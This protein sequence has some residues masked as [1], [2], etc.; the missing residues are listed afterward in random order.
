[1][2]G[3]LQPYLSNDVLRSCGRRFPLLVG[4]PFLVLRP[5]RGVHLCYPGVRPGHGNAPGIHAETALGVSRWSRRHGRRWSA[6]LRGLAAPSVRERPRAVAAALLHV[7]H[8]DDLGA[9]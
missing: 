8:R 9:D 7:L 3:D 4:E 5:P 1:A 2:D 6:E